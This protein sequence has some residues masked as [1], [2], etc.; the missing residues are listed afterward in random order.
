MCTDKKIL[1]EHDERRTGCLTSQFINRFSFS[2]LYGID[3]DIQ[4]FSDFLD[5]LPFN[6]LH[7]DLPTPFAQAS[8]AHPQTTIHLFSYRH[9]KLIIGPPYLLDIIKNRI[10]GMDIHH[11]LF[12]AMD[13]KTVFVYGAI[14][15]KGQVMRIVE[16]NLLMPYIDKCLLHDILGL[17]TAIDI[18]L[19]ITAQRRIITVEE[20]FPCSLISLV[21]LLYV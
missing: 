16:Q 13:R 7:N 18:I 17:K 19:G 8:D 1:Q 15:I 11:I 14:K 4:F 2:V 21:D 6:G 9:G 10:G 20:N 3:R 5:R 12:W